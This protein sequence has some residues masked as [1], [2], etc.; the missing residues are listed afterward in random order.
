M[1]QF[2]GTP[3]GAVS[4]N[5]KDPTS[6]GVTSMPDLRVARWDGG[7]WRNRGGAPSG[8][9][10]N[11][12]LLTNLAPQELVFAPGWWTL[13]SISASN[14]LPIELLSFTARPEGRTVRLDWVTA[15]ET[16]NDYFTVERSKNGSD[17]EEVLR[18][19]GAGTSVTAISY[20]D[21]DPW[22]HAGVSYYRLRQTDFN[23]TT[24]T[25]DLVS[26]R[27][28]TEGGNGLALV[29]S[30][31]EVIAIHDFATGSLIHVMDMT[32]RMVWQGRVETEGRS[33]IPTRNLP[34]GAYLI[35]VSDDS[36]IES[37]PFVK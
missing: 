3:V 34:V 13:A 11:G 37:A 16:D 12:T 5:W 19:Q 36:R 1:D 32:G 4:L 26:V 6:C 18:K 17:F 10:F 33:T 21:L 31:E 27:M 20:T 15:T 23:N 22:P 29:N 7:M 25:S 9:V 30:S 14:P 35:R 8:F 24:T 28:P 2:T